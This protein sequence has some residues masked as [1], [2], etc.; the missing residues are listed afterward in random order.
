MSARWGLF[1]VLLVSFLFRFWLSTDTYLHE[2]DE[3][4]HALVAK[5]L[6]DN[7]LKPTLYAT[8]VEPYD[9]RDWINNHI[10]LSKPPI[11]LW[12]MAG[13]LKAFGINELAVRIPALVLATLSALLVFLMARRFCS[14]WYAVLASSLF[15]FHGLLTDLCTGR[16]S[17][18]S[19][20][21]C[22]LFF[23]TWGMY[24]V[25]RKPLHGFKMTDYLF[26]GCLTGFAFLSKWQPA[27][28]I[29][30]VAFIA[31]FNIKMIWKHLLG[32]TLS[33]IVAAIIG[34]AWLG[35]CS[36]Q[37]PIE[38]DWLIHSLFLPMY[39]ETVSPDG[40]WYSYLT[41]FGNFFGYTTYIL[42]VIF[43]VKMIRE[44]T[45]KEQFIT[46]LAMLIWIVLPLII[47]SF[48]EAKRGTYLFI[49]APAIF[50]LIA[51]SL[52]NAK[53]RKL[54]SRWLSVASV[55]FIIGYSTDKAVN[56]I[57]KEHSRDWSDELKSRKYNQGEVIYGEPHY[58][59]A[60]FYHDITAYPN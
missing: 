55:V 38:T 54:W 57:G 45:D 22:F 2:F 8:P 41:D 35:Y 32:M 44:R 20:E 52:E 49:S 24:F 48:A 4:Y 40:T 59:E 10:W 19:V 34:G 14:E 51:Y 33:V 26:V 6:I 15:A 31:H 12:L 28:I 30:L 7:P 1:A 25:F 53:S 27:L 36:V 11:P 23:I 47:F 29:P 3:R 42:V 56:I 21:T 39:D 58:I 60:M 9:H 13:S 43:S 46:K 18:D 5:H 37:F 16:L 17:S 50:I